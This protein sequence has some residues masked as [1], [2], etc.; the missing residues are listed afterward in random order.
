MKKY[1]MTGI[2]AVAISAAFTSCSKDTTFEQITPEMISEANYENA[3]VSRFGEIA[4]KQDW[5]FGQFKKGANARTRA[6]IDANGNMW[7]YT[8][9][10]GST[11][12]TDVYS[13]VNTLSAKTKVVPSDLSTYFVT[14]IY[15]GSDTHGSSNYSND[16]MNQ[17]EFA[18]SSPAS[19][20]W[21]GQ[22]QGSWFH[23]YDFNSAV[24]TDYEGNM[25]V[26]DTPPLNFAYKNSADSKW[27]DKWIGVDGANIPKT[28]GGNYAGNYYICFDFEAMPNEIYTV[29]EMPEH[30]GAKVNVTGY[31]KD[32]TGQDLID[33]GITS[34]T[35]PATEWTEEVTYTV[36]AN[37]FATQVQYE[38]MYAP[39][40]D[41]YTDWIIRLVKAE[42]RDDDFPAADVRVLAED[43]NITDTFNG[44]T[45][46]GDFDFNDAVFD[47]VY[48][49][50][51]TTWIVLQAAGGTYPLY[52][53]GHEI[54]AAF[55]CA[56]NDMVNTSGSRRNPVRINLEKSYTDANEIP[57]TV[58]LPTGTRT[59]EAGVGKA[60]HKLAVDKDF[61]WMG[62][63]VSI[64]TQYPLFGQWV[65]HADTK[66]Y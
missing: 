49:Y 14:H 2:A 42:D 20:S 21:D 43:L 62:E 13:Y 10:V 34:I 15:K 50:K 8:P 46:K 58:D 39:G 26:I 53:D 24:S 5:G 61:Q 23:V 30:N 56:T 66:W 1:L 6:T 51:G 22:Q 17:L 32:K 47:V 65:K 44:E 18:E 3:F 31:W 38:N 28:G 64:E 54:H 33:A 25:L 16:L 52:V 11:E 27:H 36:Q 12:R 35:V 9:T 48:D 19:I 55:G 57:I 45:Y 4:S 60:P 40:N 41:N 59:L 29:F 37:W 7:P 63:Q